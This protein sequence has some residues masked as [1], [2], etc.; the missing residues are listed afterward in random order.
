M[1]SLA[2]VVIVSPAIRKVITEGTDLNL[3]VH[4]IPNVEYQ[5]FRYIDIEVKGTN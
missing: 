1:S 4:L 3:A 5:D 2:N